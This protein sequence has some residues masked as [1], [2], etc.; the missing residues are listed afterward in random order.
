MRYV[1]VPRAGGAKR[2]RA[3]GCHRRGSAGRRSPVPRRHRSWR[4][5]CAADAPSAAAPRSAASEARTAA[6]PCVVAV[7]GTIS[8]AGQRLGGR[9]GPA[10]H[11]RALVNAPSAEDAPALIEL[12]AAVGGDRDGTGRAQCGQVRRPGL[13]WIGPTLAGTAR[14]WN[15]W[16]RNCRARVQDGGRAAPAVGVRVGAGWPTPA[17]T[18]P[19]RRPR[20]THGTDSQHPR[21]R[22]AEARP[23]QREV[24]E[25]VAWR[26]RPRGTGPGR[27]RRPSGG[28]TGQGTRPA[29]PRHRHLA[30]RCLGPP[31]RPSAADL[32]GHSQRALVRLSQFVG[33]SS[34]QVERLAAPRP[35]G[36]GS[37]AQGVAAGSAGR[38]RSGPA[39]GRHR[40]GGSAWRRQ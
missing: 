29:R 2:Y 12:D 22:Q 14:A 37:L 23:L 34:Q 10:E 21:H 13:A 7:S 32:A 16:G 20:S 17:A 27:G 15:C 26:R 8:P 25:D 33:R 40:R 24:G 4:R 28:G 11:V 1:R 6:R 5:S 38:S 30:L 31:G 3:G 9:P 19:S 35:S 39:T 18:T 36:P